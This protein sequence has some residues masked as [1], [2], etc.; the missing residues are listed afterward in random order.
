MKLINKSDSHIRKWEVM[1][2]T[3]RQGCVNTSEKL[4]HDN[5][6]LPVH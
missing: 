1:S 5:L 4:L 2:N 6:A 3:D